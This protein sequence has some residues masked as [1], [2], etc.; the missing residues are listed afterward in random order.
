M[1]FEPGILGSDFICISCNPLIKSQSFPEWPVPLPVPGM[2]QG[3]C[4]C[5]KGWRPLLPRARIH[6]HTPSACICAVKHQLPTCSVEVVCHYVPC[7]LYPLPHCDGYKTCTSPLNFLI[8]V[9]NSRFLKSQNPCTTVS[10][11]PNLLP[12]MFNYT[13]RH[14][15]DLQLSVNHGGQNAMAT[16]F[17]QKARHC[18]PLEASTLTLGT[19]LCRVSEQRSAD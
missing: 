16:S 19:D 12:L 7:E 6:F 14:C 4:R 3:H 5:I 17:R 11:Q 18:V 10:I 9:C 8:G 2:G 15:N 13:N 1:K